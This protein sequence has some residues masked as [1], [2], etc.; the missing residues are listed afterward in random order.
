MTLIELFLSYCILCWCDKFA[1]S[2]SSSEKIYS[3]FC[4]QQSSNFSSIFVFAKKMSIEYEFKIPSQFCG[5]YFFNQGG[6]SLWVLVVFSRFYFL[7]WIIS[8][9][10]ARRTGAPFSY[11]YAFKDF[12]I[13][14]TIFRN[15]QIKKLYHF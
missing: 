10:Y 12:R 6:T 15:V 1:I 4:W 7:S 8:V 14:S 5:V 2:I 11:Q 13:L 3:D 9:F